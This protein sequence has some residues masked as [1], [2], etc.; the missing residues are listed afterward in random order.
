MKIEKI[1]AEAV[2]NNS[3]ERLSNRPTAASRFGRGG[4]TPHELKAYQDR[5]ARIAIDKI[6]ELIAL[7]NAGASPESIA[8]AITTPIPVNDT[9]GEFKTLYEVM[10]D[11]ING[12][13]AGY[14]KLNGLTEDNLQAELERLEEMIAEGGGSGGGGITSEQDPT[15]PDWAKQPEKPK[16]NAQEVGARPD[17]WT[18]TASDVGALPAGTKIPSKTSDL[19]NDSGFAT[20]L[21]SDLI[22]YYTKSQTY[23]RDEI[24]ALVSNIPKF[25]IEVVDTL[26]TS[27]I[28]ESTV[29]L[30]KTGTEG[31]LYTEY[32]YVKNAWDPLGRQRVDLTG[33]A[34]EDWVNQKL[35]DYLRGEDLTIAINLALASAKESGEFDGSD[36][37]RGTGILNTTTGIASYTTAVGGVSPKYRILLSTLKTQSK[38]NEVLV[39]D[40][41]RYSTF[42]YPVIYVDS[43][44]VYMTAR[45]SIKGADGAAGKDGADGAPGADGK[46]AYAYAQEGGYTGTEAE[47]AEKLAEDVAAVLYTEQTLT[48]AQKAQARANIGATA[49]EDVEFAESV[50]W[51]N[52]N[53]DT[54]KKYVLPD[55]YIYTYTQKTVAVE[56][57]ANDGTGTLNAR[58][59]AS[60]GT[61]ITDNTTKN[62][63]FTTAAVAI[64]KTK[65]GVVNISGLEKIVNTFFASLYVYYFD[66]SGNYV[67]YLAQNTYGLSAT[68]DE[69]LTLPLSVDIYADG[70]TNSISYWN[71]A[72][73]IRI[74]V[75][76][77]KSAA[78]TASDIEGLVINFEQLNSTETVYGWYSTGQQHSNDKATQQ[79]SADIATLKE[80]VAE[81]KEAVS[82]SPTNSG[83]VWYAIGDSIT[84]GLYSTSFENYYQ[85]IVGK[86]WVDYV[87]KHN[88]Y[89]L[90]NLGVSGSGFVSGTTFRTVV[91]RNDFS[92]VDLVTIMLG[93]N[94]W[95]NTDAVNKVGTMSD[96]VGTSYTD[97]IIPELRYGIEKIITDNPYCKIILI[98]PINAKI[99]S[100]GTEDTNWAY[101][102]SGSITPCG[103]L[104]NFNEKLKEVCEYYGIQVVD[105]T[106]SSV[107]NRKS[108]T[109][110]LPDGIHPNL[111]CYKALGL[112]LARKI[113]FA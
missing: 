110:V 102:F 74:C 81:L 80:E 36:G 92:N 30:L 3:M 32:I 62:G 13:A 60:S 59:T 17:T 107:V 4:M 104:K 9:D 52:E 90:T 96:S 27:G 21:V 79:N 26:P 54:S 109:T 68:A 94:D 50:E 101:G 38:V 29:Y 1:S 49:G 95:K 39:G 28:S 56:H 103:S 51:L 93:I 34:T 15:V 84:Y 72:G 112:E 47:F 45:V 91:D 7:F 111:E 97:K 67:G 2:L 106:N 20:R 23:T 82:T 43:E 18:P 11:L 5:L 12:D 66:A 31:D 76:I 55:G 87:A 53:G 44:Y 63:L 89:E 73:Y 78:I 100:R 58:P 105:M 42:L 35:S 6:N 25:S 37:Q 98:T 113:T 61:T 48:E 33:Y 24:N 83:A 88:G 108:I 40:T 77:N 85:P 57:N 64:D 86:R 19:S 69:E 8:A 75:G 65:S 70:K 22:N 16:Y 41:V 99:G 14:F 10:D 46:S 71:Q